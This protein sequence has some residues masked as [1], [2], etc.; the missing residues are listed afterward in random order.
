[1]SFISLTTYRRGVKL[2]ART[3]MILATLVLAA[4]CASPRDRIP[5]D[6]PRDGPVRA[7]EAEQDVGAGR[8]AHLG[9]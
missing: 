8:P 1:M 7:V 2:M 5:N 3:T 4:G 9:G 6:V